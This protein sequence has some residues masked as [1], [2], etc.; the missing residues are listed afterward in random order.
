LFINIRLLVLKV[1][2]EAIL[3]LPDFVDKIIK[4]MGNQERFIIFYQP[5]HF[6][7]TLYFL[8]FQLVVVASGHHAF[9]IQ[10]IILVQLGC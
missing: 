9:P 6:N 2:S 10:E 3:N 8:F 1:R 4:F 5:L 7:I